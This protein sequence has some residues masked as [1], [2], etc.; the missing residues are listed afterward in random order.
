MTLRMLTG[1]LLSFLTWFFTSLI[2]TTSYTLKTVTLV[3]TSFTSWFDTLTGDMLFIT[4][5]RPKTLTRLLFR[6]TIIQFKLKKQRMFG[7][8]F[9]LL[10]QR[11]VLRTFILSLT[12]LFTWDTILFTLVSLLMTIILRWMIRRH[13][14]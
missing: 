8:F 14:T 4:V 7:P 11:L 3:K 10:L 9:L 6:I 12:T 1:L 5:I 2:D 13:F